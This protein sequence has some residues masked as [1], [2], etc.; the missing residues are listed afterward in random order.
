MRVWWA[1]ALESVAPALVDRGS[2]MVI[3]ATNKMF[4]LT[5]VLFI[6]CVV[7]FIVLVSLR[8]NEKT[9]QWDNF[10]RRGQAR[11]TDNGDTN[12]WYY[13]I[14]DLDKIQTLADIRNI[15]RSS[16]LEVT[17]TGF[18]VHGIDYEIAFDRVSSVD[19]I[20][21]PAKR[22]EDDYILTLVKQKIYP[23]DVKPKPGTVKG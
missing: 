1:V 17:H 3:S 2:K 4:L 5:F 22:D 10:I 19:G 9:L 11:R 18:V 21:D 6:L 15:E 14:R 13:V 23:W 8:R 16:R 7:L 20:L 12:H